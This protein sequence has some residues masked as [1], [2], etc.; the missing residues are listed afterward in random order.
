VLLEASCFASP[1][2][3]PGTLALIDPTGIAIGDEGV[4]LS[5]SD[6]ATVEMA[7]DADGSGSVV[8]LWQVGCVGLLIR[9]LINWRMMR[10][11]ASILTEIT[12]T[13]ESA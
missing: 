6:Q 13:E 3:A 2:A 12:Y 5:S 10:P 4:E 7:D 11:A 9:R 1:Y 8:S